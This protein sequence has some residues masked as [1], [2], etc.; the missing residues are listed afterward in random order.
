VFDSYN[1]DD[2][3]E[4]DFSKYNSEQFWDNF[5]YNK[6]KTKIQELAAEFS[7]YEIDENFVTIKAGELYSPRYYNFDTDNIE[8][9]VEFDKVKLLENLDKNDFNT[10]LK[11]NYS[12]YDGF[13][14]FTA[15]NFD[16]WYIDYK[17]EKE[18]AI[19]ALLT[20]LFKDSEYQESF[21]LYVYE[22]IGFYSDFYIN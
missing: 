7:M 12:Y 15:N 2:D 17:D 20:Y 6:Y 4:N 14:S 22:N 13:Y 11:E 5:D 18:T 21:N 8:L 19:G 9:T 16:E 10:F 3:F 1:I